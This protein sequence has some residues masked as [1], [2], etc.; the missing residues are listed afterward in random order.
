MAL[1]SPQPDDISRRKRFMWLILP[2]IFLFA[3]IGLR[4]WTLQII[5][6][7][8]YE[9]LSQKNRT[10]YIPIAA[11]RGAI[12]DRDGLLLVDNRPSFTVSA[13]RQEVVDKQLLLQNLATYLNCDWHQLD[14]DWNKRRYFPQ[15]RPIPLK[16]DIDRAVLERLA[17]NSVTLPGMLIE[18]Q[19]MR[20]YPFRE[21]AAHLF[22][23]IGAITQEEL[24]RETYRDYNAGDFIGKTGLEKHLESY[25]RGTAGEKLVE[26]D[27]KGK[28]LRQLQVRPALPGNSV[29][30]TLQLDLQLRTEQ[31]FGDHAGAAV[32]LDVNNGEILAMVSRPA[33][34]PEMF[35]RGITSKEW[36]ALVNNPSNP[37]QDKS[38]SGQY[39][40]GSTYKMV[41]ALAALQSGAITPN[42]II[43]CAGRTTIGNR[44]FRCWKKTGHGAT[45]LRK[46]LRESCDVWFYEVSLRVGVERMS[47]MARQLGL[48]RSYD[49]PLDNEKS[50]LIP[51]KK[52][53]LQRY[54]LPWYPGETAI[55][56]IG[57]GYVLATPLQLAVMTATIANGGTL[58]RPQILK[59]ITTPKGKTIKT[60]APE[61]IH[62][63]RLNQQQ[64]NYV[65]QGM[66][67]V[68]NHPRGTGKSSALPYVMVAGKTG[69]AQVIRMKDDPIDG[70]LIDVEE[71]AYRHRDHALFVAYAPAK[72]P[73]IAVAIIVEHGQHG[74]SAAGPIARQIF[75]Q[76]FAPGKKENS[77]QPERP[78]N[79]NQQ[80]HTGANDV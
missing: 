24:G 52:W 75:E 22:G 31:A 12:Y 38:L 40:P 48:G 41:T 30:L 61:K 27:V 8:R 69:T 65:K 32:V 57:Q 11:P 72:K 59:T 44:D 78:I 16:Q 66:E 53:K 5:Y 79:I 74:G 80:N 1:N 58:Y 39:P 54:N 37:L 68:V 17:E 3:L 10:R 67:E 20:A 55:A 45:N 14:Q 28:Q 51:D 50:G 13:L 77:S 9:L 25:L 70:E 47:T 23:H 18:V 36:S 29:F 33:F 2:A 56:A 42:T 71:I 26:V 60:Y 19:P 7:E 63:S 49:L 15:Y 43:D 76:Y 6:G 64:L 4:L 35:A 73:Q 46:A 34:D 21:V 62:D